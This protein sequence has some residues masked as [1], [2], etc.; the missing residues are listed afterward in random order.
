MRNPKWHRDEIILALDLYLNPYRGSIDSQNP[1]IIEL[2]ELLNKLPIFENKPEND[3]F[4]NPNGVSLKMSNFLAIDPNYPGKGMTAYSKLDKEVFDE[5]YQDRPR[6]IKVA[7]AI[8][9]ITENELLNE[10]LK[11]IEFDEVSYLDSVQEGQVLYKLH[12]YRER[13]NKIVEAKKKSVLKSTGRL[14]CEVCNF[15]FE[16]E[17]GSI[18]I[19]FIECHHTKPLSNYTDTSETKLEDLSLV[20]SNCHRMLHRKIDTL[21]I[22]DL[23]EVKDTDTNSL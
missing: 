1:N 19:G 23:K 6:L 11:R 16:K 7:R 13:N 4:R 5:F 18:G 9:G 15:D 17:Y 12:K 3:K 20:C 21:T 22:I 8:K 10:Q 14:S 2:S